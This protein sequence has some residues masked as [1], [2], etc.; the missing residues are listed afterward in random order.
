MH[1]DSMNPN[2]GWRAPEE[3]E[4]WD[5]DQDLSDL[6]HLEPGGESNPLESAPLAYNPLNHAYRM[7]ADTPVGI[8]EVM[9]KFLIVRGYE[10]PLDL[11]NNSEAL[12][13]PVSVEDVPITEPEGQQF[14]GEKFTGW[15]DEV[16][17]GALVEEIT[18]GSYYM[19]PSI[20]R[21]RRLASGEVTNADT[22]ELLTEDEVAA[23]IP[24]PALLELILGYAKHVAD[25]Q[26]APAAL[27]DLLDHFTG[28]YCRSV[29]PDV[30]DDEWNNTD[31]ELN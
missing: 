6:S 23:L 17:G 25:D 31:E 8:V 1:Y 15:K 26:S 13:I 28:R 12:R 7:I 18:G 22:W 11:L 2:S 21:A 30:S 4:P 19:I 5:P 9:V 27:K 29:A 10:L 14:Y 16:A 3:G 20:V 24:G